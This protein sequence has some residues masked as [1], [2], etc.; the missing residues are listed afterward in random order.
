MKA[1]LG[2]ESDVESLS[3]EELQQRRVELNEKIRE[4]GGPL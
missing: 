2:L 4:G 3:H 1:S